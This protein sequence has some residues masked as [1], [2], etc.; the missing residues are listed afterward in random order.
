MRAGNALARSV[1]LFAWLGLIATLVAPATRAADET[2]PSRP[3]D[4]IVPWGTGGGADYIGRTSE[5]IAANPGRV[6]TGPKYSR[7]NG[8]DWP[9][10]DAGCQSRWLH[11][12]G[13]DF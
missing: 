13:S 9:A 5:G 8:A 11:H 1:L 12:R 6:A 7:R 3:I 4:L 2:Y 10:Q